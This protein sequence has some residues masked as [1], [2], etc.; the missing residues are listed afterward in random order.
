MLIL[1]IVLVLGR[2]MEGLQECIQ[3]L[4][5]LYGVLEEE[6]LEI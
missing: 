3:T 6:M 1:C 4:N 5:E 2:I